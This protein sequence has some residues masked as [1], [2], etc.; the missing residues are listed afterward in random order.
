MP[1]KEAPGR[2]ANI[3]RILSLALSPKSV[4]LSVYLIEI[5]KWTAW[6]CGLDEGRSGVVPEGMGLSWE[7]N[8][9][10]HMFKATKFRLSFF[11]PWAQTEGGERGA[12]A[13]KEPAEPR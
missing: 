8:S 6:S 2:S 13:S 4:N 11:R 12:G 7:V 10:A 1:S 9:R 5:F 3:V